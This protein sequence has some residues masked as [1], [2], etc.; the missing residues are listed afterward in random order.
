M[1]YEKES[2]FLIVAALVMFTGFELI[3]NQIHPKA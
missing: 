2:T 3:F 1:N